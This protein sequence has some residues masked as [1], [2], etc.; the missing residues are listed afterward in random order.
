MTERHFELVL[1]GLLFPE[2]PRWHD[3]RLWFADQHLKRVF[4]VDERGTAELVV[5]VPNHPSGLGWDAEG[6]LLIVSMNDRRLLRLDGRE[7]T[8]VADLSPYTHFHC[9]DMVV[10]GKG[11]AYIGNFGFDLWSGVAPSP[12]NLVL[13]EPGKSIRVVASGLLFPNGMVIT[14][15][16][17]TLILS[18]TFGERLLAFDIEADGS[19]S[20]RRVWAHIGRP[21]DGICLDAEGLVWA[22]VPARPGAFLHVA[23]GGA[24]KERIS[25]GEY[26]GFACMLG[27]PDGRTLFLLEARD[28]RPGRMLENNGRIRSVRVEAPHAGRP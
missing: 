25:G 14:P 20:N 22:A 15:D 1:D 3:G 8:Q 26:G 5:E 17:R 24:I 2:C 12:T 19:L 13:V 23:E 16:E 18:E 4:V 27:G 7:L 6:R 28:M 21:T 10:D 11:R 9:N